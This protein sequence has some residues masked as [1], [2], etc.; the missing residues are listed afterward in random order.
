MSEEIKTKPLSAAEFPSIKPE[1]IDDANAAIAAEKLSKEATAKSIAD[2]IAARVVELKTYEGK[3][4]K[5]KNPH[6]Q[7]PKQTIKVERYAGVSNGVYLFQVESK[8]PGSRWTPPATKFLDE[9]EE[10]AIKPKTTSP[11]II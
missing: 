1:I 5:P 8:N 3:T 2:K 11:E 9:H 4:F 7:F 6:V 10:V